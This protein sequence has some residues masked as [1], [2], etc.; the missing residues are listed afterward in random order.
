MFLI[1]TILAGLEYYQRQ[2]WTNDD[3]FG[4]FPQ[5][6][7]ILFLLDIYWFLLLLC[8]VVIYFLQFRAGRKIIGYI[9]LL[10]A[11]ENTTMEEQ[12]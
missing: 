2:T 10:Q 1:E 6:K 11:P 8:Y 7:L 3:K 12:I 5:F 4:N 9:D